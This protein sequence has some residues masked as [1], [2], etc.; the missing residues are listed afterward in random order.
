MAEVGLAWAGRFP[1]LVRRL[2]EYYVAYSQYPFL[3]GHGL[4]LDT[5][6]ILGTLTQP[7]GGAS[8]L[9]RRPLLLS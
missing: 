9:T 4:F 6:G 5:N 1:V 8:L 7:P 2:S 3:V